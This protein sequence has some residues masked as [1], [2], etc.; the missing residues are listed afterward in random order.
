MAL[1]STSEQPILYTLEINGGIVSDM[2][3]VPD[4]LATTMTVY[5]DADPGA[6]VN[7]LPAAKFPPLPDSGWLEQGAIYA[8][9]GVCVM[10]RQPHNRTIY[11]PDQTP[12]LFVVYRPG[13][14][15]LDWIAGEPVEIGI[16]RMYGGTEYVCLQKHVTQ[17]D[18]TPPA[19]PALWRVYTP[20]PP[21][22]S[23]WAYPIAY[24]IGDIVTYTGNRYQC[25]QA[26]TSQA[27]WTPSIVPAL[28]KKL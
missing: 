11:P 13:E 2:L 1:I 21:S 8:Y 24:K 26:H 23:P 5:Y 27:G 17:S 4:K 12:A 10:V 3:H 20:T 14:G 19:V 25:L 9:G 18:W 15:V 28:W 6:Y 22:E 16:H 7:K